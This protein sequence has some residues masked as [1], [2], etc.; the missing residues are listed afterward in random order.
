M[1]FL[2]ISTLMVLVYMQMN[3]TLSVYLRDSHGVSPEGYGY[4]LSLNA[5][6]VVL[7][8]FWV[9][10]RLAGNPPLIL[11]F[12]GTLFYA[13][14]FAMYGFVSTYL[15]F[16]LAMVIITIGEMIVSPTAQA[17]VSRLAPANM[18][19]RYMAAY[20][21]TWII[22]SALGP[23]AAGVILDNYNPNWVW[24]LSGIISFIAAAGYAWL[25]GRARRRFKETV[26]EASA[27]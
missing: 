27:P 7:F 21:F 23:W 4:L 14:G 22:P 24:Y 19:G 15:L 9:T 25:H 12:V 5:V 18:R 11:M 20:G 10:R 3:T 1:A 8:Q 17:L 16:M 26:Q 2:F 13:L 6:M